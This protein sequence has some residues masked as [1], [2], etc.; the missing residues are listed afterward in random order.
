M[1]PRAACNRKARG[2]GDRAKNNT[3]RNK[4]KL[5]LVIGFGKS[6]LPRVAICAPRVRTEVASTCTLVKVLLRA[7]ESEVGRPGGRFDSI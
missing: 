7:K 6:A 1:E 3:K 5:L 2:T 4:E